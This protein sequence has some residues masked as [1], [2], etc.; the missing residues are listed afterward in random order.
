[1]STV[2]PPVALAA[3]A[4]AP[5][6]RADPIRTGI[7]A[8]KISLAGFIIPFVFVYHP[9]MLYKLQVL[10]EWFGEG[11]VTSKAMIDISTVSWFDFSWIIVAFTLA[12]WLIASALAGFD[13][14]RLNLPERLL[15]VI[16]GFAALFPQL[17]IALPAALV[18]LVLI[19]ASPA[20]RGRQT[21]A[22]I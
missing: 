2:T 17:A 6:A 15:R 9:A 3:F 12:M 11:P 18:G 8:A 20:L 5:I 19:L 1:M 4:A 22:N 13:R 14:N 7:E 21:P 16:L 10:F